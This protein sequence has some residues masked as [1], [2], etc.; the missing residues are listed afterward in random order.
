MIIKYTFAIQYSTV[1]SIVFNGIPLEEKK[2]C[3]CCDIDCV[4]DSS[5][6]TINYYTDTNSTGNITETTSSIT[7]SKATES[8]NITY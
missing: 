2:N 1:G 6:G 5:I 8:T 7:V 4:E 3:P